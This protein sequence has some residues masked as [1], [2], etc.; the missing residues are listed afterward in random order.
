[1]TD[2]V[3]AHVVS[4]DDEAVR[5]ARDLLPRPAVGADRRDAERELPWEQVAQIRASGLL[6]ITVPRSH[7]GAGAAAAT[8]AEA[9]R[10]VGT[11]D[12]SLAQILQPHFAFLDSL[13]RSGGEEVRNR[14][15]ADV[16]AGA[17][18]GNAQAE[19]TGRNSH[20]QRT[21]LEPAGDGRYRI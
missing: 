17:L 11:V 21:R 16:L 5:I 19:R 6:G 10:L 3:T 12:L 8:V 1:M 14:V 2:T 13:R 20:E 4:D 15:F 9:L 18:V 7:G